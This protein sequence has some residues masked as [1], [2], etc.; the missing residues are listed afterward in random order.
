MNNNIVFLTNAQFDAQ[1]NR[2]RHLRAWF[3]QSKS[4]FVFM[5]VKK[6]PNTVVHSSRARVIVQPISFDRQL[7]NSNFFSRTNVL[8]HYLRKMD[9]RNK[10]GL[11]VVWLTST[12]KSLGN[13][14]NAW[15]SESRACRSVT[16]WRH[17]KH[18]KDCEKK[19]ARECRLQVCQ[20]K[21]Q[22]NTVFK[23]TFSESHVEFVDSL[24]LQAQ[25]PTATDIVGQGGTTRQSPSIVVEW[26]L[27]VFARLSST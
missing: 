2:Q 3:A 25:V 20:I 24:L 15:L 18:G 7:S 17:W 13:I 6:T 23:Q 22:K 5:V 14:H 16:K 27:S 26:I 11:C 4:R 8:N 1:H 21:D 12:P 10:M 19:D 9:A